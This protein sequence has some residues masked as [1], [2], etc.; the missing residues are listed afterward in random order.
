M[1]QEVESEALRKSFEQILELCLKTVRRL[2]SVLEEGAL[3]RPATTGTDPNRSMPDESKAPD[4][5]S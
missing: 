3:R 4:L 1:E 5:L 2:R